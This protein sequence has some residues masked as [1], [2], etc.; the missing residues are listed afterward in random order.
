MI[1]IQFHADRQWKPWCLAVGIDKDITLWW[2]RT[3]A[4]LCLVMPQILDEFE[5]KSQNA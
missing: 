4:E 2:F 5:R 1:T 3:R